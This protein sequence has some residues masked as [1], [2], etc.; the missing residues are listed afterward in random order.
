MTGHLRM[1]SRTSAIL[2]AVV[3]IL[4]GVVVYI[5]VVP[6]SSSPSAKASPPA[7]C[8]SSS[9]ASSGSNGTA[10]TWTTYHGDNTR[11]GTVSMGN[12]TAVRARWSGP[13]AL[14]GQVYAQPLVCGNSVF[15][16]TEADTIYA[17]NASSGSVL[18]HTHLGGPVPGS[19]LPCGDID[20]SGITGTP[21][22]DLATRTIYAVAFLA[23]GQHYLFGLNI[24]NGSVLSKVLVD[25]SGANPLVE[26][27]RGA[28][29]LANRVVYVPYGG[30]DGDCGDYH[31]W[32]VGV[33]VEG[34]GGLLSYEVPTSREGGI[35]SPAG[36][37][38]TADG[39]LMVATGNSASTTT[40]DY[41]DSV[42]ELSPALK[43][44]DY[45]SPTNWAQL[46]GGDVDL[47]STAPTVLPNGNVFQIG[48]EGV[49]FLLS[50]T[51]LGGVGGQLYNASVCGG[52]YSGTAHVG[53]TV[54]IGCN[55]GLVRVDVGFANFSVTW[56]TSGFMTGAPVVTG[57]I[58]WVV[59]T[60]SGDLRGFNLSNGQQAYSLSL[61]S[62]DSFITPAATPT[63]LFVAG[64]AAFDAFT[65]T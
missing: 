8:S 30:L 20:P 9:G 60:P 41:G 58:V 50:G 63:S 62:A 59:D 33:P 2:I 54:L 29:A 31:G 15:V 37:V 51:R 22:I 16:A 18:W 11:S 19:A 27:Q 13:T 55:D 39:N 6:S 1:S 35:W 5:V 42:I 25:P 26:Q 21:V 47:G 52:A 61:G 36:V 4:A 10:G 56:T 17:V 38:V 43:V 3:V 23:S 64:G 12:V 24:D 49:G 32:V 48:K 65:L 7:S 34:S 14:D 46:N 40:F 28:L 44:V 45:F 53:T 57:N